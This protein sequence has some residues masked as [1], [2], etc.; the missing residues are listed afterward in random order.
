MPLFVPSHLLDAPKRQPAAPILGVYYGLRDITGRNVALANLIQSLTTLRRSD[1]IRW[2]CA[3]TQWVSKPDSFTTDN[4][5]AIADWVLATELRDALKQHVTTE[6]SKTWCFI[7]RRQLLFLLQIAAISCLE[8]VI[9]AGEEPFRLQLGEC[10]LMANDIL[11]QIETTGR[12]DDDPKDANDR[13]IEVV[14]SFL[15]GQDRLEVLARANHFWFD[16]PNELPINNHFSALRMPTLDTAFAA[17]HEVPLREFFLIAYALYLR[18]AAHSTDSTNPLLLD[19]ASY[20]WPLFDKTHVHHVLRHLSQTTDE[21]AVAL[22]TQP[23]QNWTTDFTPLRERPL[24][25]VFDGKYACTDLRLLYRCLHDRLYFLLQQSYPDKSFRQLFGYIFQEYITRLIRQFGSESEILVR[26]FF[27]SPRFEGKRD[28]AGDGIL[29]WP[30]LALVMEYKARLLT[31]REKYGGMTDVMLRG[32]DDIIGT[33]RSRKGVYQLA[34]VVSRLL[35][36]EKIAGSPKSLD[37]SEHP[38]IHPVLVVYEEAMGLE[39]VRQRAHAKFAAALTI[40]DDERRRQVGDL[41]IL[42]VEEMET[43]QAL[44]ARHPAEKILSDYAQHLKSDQKTPGGSFR[45]F[46]YSSEYNSNFP[47]ASETIVGQL[48]KR[49]ADQLGVELNRRYAMAMASGAIQCEVTDT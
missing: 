46:I 19:E 49:A 18:F 27:A 24:I 16:L 10:L 40:N 42:T 14:L 20:L 39:L 43:L 29:A 34:N 12:Q 48:Y 13:M 11:Q 32:I 30:S 2:T 23:R 44:A 25:H 47:R 33:E 4:Q 21:L 22:L 6:G 26:T 7:H 36:G 5:L 45:S 28:E 9:S 38:T 8:D 3:L 17:K 1:V 15:D 41:L 37:L 35:K 31:T